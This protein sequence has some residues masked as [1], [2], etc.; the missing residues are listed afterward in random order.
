MNDTGMGGVAD[1]VTVD[2]RATVTPTGTLRLEYTVHNAAAG[3]VGV[4]NRIPGRLPNGEA[5][6]VLR[7]TYVDYA[8]GELVVRAM[9]LPDPDD[10]I[11]S[12]IHVLPY[13]SRVRAG[14]TLTDTIELP[15]PV[16]VDDPNRRVKLLFAH[17]GMSIGAT[18]PREAQSVKL[19]VGLFA[20]TPGVPLFPAD[21]ADP[22]VLSIRGA[23]PRQFT[24][25]YRTRLP[26]PVRVLDLA[27]TPRPT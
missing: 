16:V 8:D 19:T 20:I 14:A 12:T 26:R 21:P 17:R 11:T 9:D 18:A 3:D 7:R 15:A 13:V 10:G 5:D 1:A 2:A 4:F 22:G 6:P 24:R 23:P 25:E 27:A